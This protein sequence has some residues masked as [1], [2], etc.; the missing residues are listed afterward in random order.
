MVPGIQVYRIGKTKKSSDNK[1]VKASAG[2]TP[3]IVY[4]SVVW[5]NHF[6]K[7]LVCVQIEYM[8]IQPSNWSVAM[9]IFMRNLYMCAPKYM[10]KM[11]TVTLAILAHNKLTLNNVGMDKLWYTYIMTSH[12]AIKKWNTKILNDL[13][14]FHRG[15]VEK[16]QMQRKTIYM[17]F[18][19]RENESVV[20]QIRVVAEAQKDM[21]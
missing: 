6:G 17:K 13:D 1:Y 5:C 7:P 21:R 19:Y 15:K 16:S 4:C 11:F 14:E 9:Y 2:R 18:K 3:D 12:V 8:C 10:C 20:I